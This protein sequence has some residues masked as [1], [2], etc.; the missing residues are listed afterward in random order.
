MEEYIAWD[1]DQ[2]AKLGLDTEVF[3]TFYYGSKTEILPGEFAS[4]GGCLLL[5]TF[6]GKPA[7]CVGYRRLSKD[8]CELKRLFVRPTYRGKGIGRSL[9]VELIQQARLSGYRIVRLE[10]V[11][12]MPE[13]HKLYQALG[14]EFCPPY[15]EIPE[16]LRPITYFME[17]R[18]GDSQNTDTGHSAIGREAA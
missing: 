4:P 14:F 9:A 16:S 10:T 7:G 6:D 5:A 11:S 12:F 17:L 3:L 15:Y 18:L 8:V 1:A 2:T 13:A